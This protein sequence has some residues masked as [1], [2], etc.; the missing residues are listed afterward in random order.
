MAIIQFNSCAIQLLFKMTIIQAD[1]R[2]GSDMQTLSAEMLMDCRNYL[3]E[4]L[5]FCFTCLLN[6]NVMALL[7]MLDNMII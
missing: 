7:P 2:K 3:L 6:K 4:T 1:M 5:N